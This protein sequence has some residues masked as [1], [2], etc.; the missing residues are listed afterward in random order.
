MIDKKPIVFL[1]GMPGSGK[2]TLARHFSLKY[3]IPHIDLDERIEKDCGCS[4]SEL[5]KQGEEFFRE[6][7]HRVL[8]QL[9]DHLNEPTII[10]CGGGTPCFYNNFEILQKNGTT[11]YIRCSFEVLT[12]NLHQQVAQNLR[13][14]L[15]EKNYISFKEKLENL[16]FTRKNYYEKASYTLD[17]VDNSADLLL[18]IYNIVKHGLFL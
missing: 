2:T 5:F 7:E 9:C 12:K 15:D 10:S 17:N 11:I 16:F 8:E 18:Q 13:P 1:I 4:I 6:T 14:I 3:H